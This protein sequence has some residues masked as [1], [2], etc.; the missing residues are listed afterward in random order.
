VRVPTVKWSAPD[1]EPF[2]RWLD[3]VKEQHGMASDNKL[4]EMLGWNHTK[5]HGWRTGRQ[6]PSFTSLT[7]LAGILGEEPRKLW[8]LAGLASAEEAGLEGSPEPQPLPRPIQELIDVYWRSD[9]NARTVLLGQVE[10]LLDGMAGR[11]ARRR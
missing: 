2:L 4:A 11:T 8:V 6:R 3:R 10:F 5:L 9:K 1:R 7:E